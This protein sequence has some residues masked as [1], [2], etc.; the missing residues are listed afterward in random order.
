MKTFYSIFTIIFFLS[1]ISFAQDYTLKTNIGHTDVITGISIDN[2]GKYI[3]S[4]SE[5]KTIILWD[6]KSGKEIKTFQGQNNALSSVAFSPD[7]Q[8]FACAEG[9]LKA[10]NKIYIW[11]I[12]QNKIIKT[13]EDNKGKITKLS[14]SKDGRYLLSGGAK[15]LVLRDIEAG[16]KIRD[17]ALPKEELIS[18]DFS[19]DGKNIIA[20]AGN[21]IYVWDINSREILKTIEG[22]SD[23]VSCIAFSKLPVMISWS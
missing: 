4:C 17:F 7:A 6:V 13:I 1:K 14:Y 10:K 16:I 21:N 11:D 18:I 5:D 3:L 2:N 9:D 8:K 19:E 23:R 20:S 15:E 22:H 12:K